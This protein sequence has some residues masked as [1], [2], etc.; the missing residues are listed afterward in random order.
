MR[1]II[2]SLCLIFAAVPANA[3]ED[4]K[5]KVLFIR[6]ALAPG[7]GDP[8][9]FKVNDCSTQRNLDERGRQQSRNIGT[10]I[11]S[12]FANWSHPIYTSQWCRCRE[13]AELMNIGPVEDFLGLNSFFTKPGKKGVYLNALEAKLAGLPRDG[14]LVIMVTHQVTI[15]AITGRGVGS[16]QGV[17]FDLATG[18]SK[19]ITLPSYK[20]L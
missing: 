14:G 1:L 18:T 7:M 8:G 15:S 9:N 12:Q 2:I 20:N 4:V 6:H 10:F 13:T 5:G 16:G 19:P 11:K 3:V 17:L